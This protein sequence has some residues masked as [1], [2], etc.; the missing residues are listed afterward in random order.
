MPER[1][2]HLG[3]F[4]G[5]EFF[6]FQFL[7]GARSFANEPA[8]VFALLM[9][10]SLLNPK[11]TGITEQGMPVAVQQFSGGNDVMKVGCRGVDAVD[12]AENVTHAYVHLHT[13]VPLITFLRL[14][15]LQIALAALVFLSNLRRDK[16]CIFR[17]IMNT[18]SGRT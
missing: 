14:V 2:L 18:H 6:G 11:K 9:L 7:P 13:E 1:V 16:S 12:Q 4:T 17:P 8:K 10:I 3:T 5:F 15:H